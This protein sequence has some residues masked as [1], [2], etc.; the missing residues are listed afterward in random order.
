MNLLFLGELDIHA[1]AFLP[2]LRNFGYNVSVMNTSLRRFPKKFKLSG[3]PVINLYEKSKKTFLF[4]G[5]LESFRKAAFYSLEENT[6]SG[7]SVPGA[8]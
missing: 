4:K 3:I 1:R 5:R 2:F 7:I 8:R 6:K